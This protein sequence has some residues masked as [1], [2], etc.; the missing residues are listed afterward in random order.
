MLKKTILGFGV[1]GLLLAGSAWVSGQTKPLKA[2]FPR[3]FV[4][5]ETVPEA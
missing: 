4:A 3:L 5:D 2:V 1:L